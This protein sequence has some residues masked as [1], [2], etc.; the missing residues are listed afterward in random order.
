MFWTGLQGAKIVCSEDVF[1]FPLRYPSSVI[2]VLYVRKRLAV[3]DHFRIVHSGRLLRDFQESVK[4]GR[5][6]WLAW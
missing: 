5:D 1:S 3:H 6:E 4:P 2:D